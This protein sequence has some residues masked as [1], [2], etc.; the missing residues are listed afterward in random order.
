MAED[1]T[2][3]DFIVEHFN[4][5]EI[6]E[7]CLNLDVDREEI[8]GTAK[9]E[10]AASLIR[11]MLRHG[12]INDLA[13]EV[14][15]ERPDLYAQKQPKLPGLWAQKDLPLWKRPQALVI[16]ILTALAVAVA[17]W[18]LANRPTWK[19]GDPVGEDFGIAVGRFLVG[20]RANSQASIELSNFIYD[21]LEAEIASDPELNGVIG[22]TT[23]DAV[24]DDE[25][26][27]EI[28]SMAEE[29]NAD[30]VVGGK[31]SL[32]LGSNIM[33][34]DFLTVDDSE[35]HII[36]TIAEHESLI[37]G[38]PQFR[39]TEVTSRTVFLA[40][41]IL[42]VG[43]VQHGTPGSLRKAVALAKKTA[44]EYED[45][46]ES[47]DLG[48]ER[49]Q[50]YFLEGVANRSLKQGQEA[51]R[52]FEMAHRLDSANLQYGLALGFQ[53]LTNGHL[54]EAAAQFEQTLESDRDN[55][56]ALWGLAAIAFDQ[57]NLEASLRYVD[58]MLDSGMLS[59][60]DTRDTE[61]LRSLL[62]FGLGQSVEAARLLEQLDVDST[63]DFFEA[64]ADRNSI[65]G[66][67]SIEILNELMR[68][69]GLLQP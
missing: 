47:A 21:V 43:L 11:Y 7:L 56:S 30:L 60:Q 66:Q 57:D 12:R 42:G 24:V 19:T 52:S 1:T 58:R 4:V 35:P 25:F 3:H 50:F 59:G 8:K 49:A 62:L 17:V 33:K 13:V 9:S 69:S 10:R 40:R 48:K 41:Y 61:A 15:K 38:E 39:I 67:L 34:P 27:V 20:N 14:E 64:M 29:V 5:S 65:L 53:L 51:Q 22:A 54:D 2:L 31:N 32:E 36:S 6:D 44:R 23:L 37:A 55:V 28:V 45:L 63:L 18:T 68:E 26:R 16:I 46:A